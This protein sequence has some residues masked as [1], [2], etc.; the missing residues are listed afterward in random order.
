VHSKLV[1]E[2]GKEISLIDLFK[3]PTIKTLANYITQ[4]NMPENAVGHGHDRAATRLK[5]R[6]Q[7]AELRKRV[8]ETKNG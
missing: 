6:N 7:Q 8:Q 1:Q 5:L 3:Y 4:E 2:F